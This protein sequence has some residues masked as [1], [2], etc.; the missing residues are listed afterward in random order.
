[1]TA[2]ELAN[3]AAPGLKAASPAVLRLLTLLQGQDASM[4]EVV[5]VLKQDAVLTAKLLR[6]CNSPSMGYA[7]PVASV[8]Q[9]VLLLGYDQMRQLILSLAFGDALGQQLSGYAVEANELWRHSLS[10]GVAAEI[11]CATFDT[12]GAEHSAA[13]TA[14]LLHDIGKLVLNQVLTPKVQADI[15]YQIAEHGLARVEAER[16]LLGC[17]HAEVGASLLRLWNLP[18]ELIE[19][20]ANHHAPILDGGHHLSPLVYLAN[21]LAHLAGSAPGWEAYAVKIQGSVVTT[22]DLSDTK[23]ERLLIRVREASDRAESFITA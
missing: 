5:A 11:T 2:L 21:C 14:G 19:G 23:I 17:D 16:H 12:G 8:E 7:E 13:F 6:A 18:E 15:L 10:V 1:M 3:K 9:A 20:V 4:E 22:Y